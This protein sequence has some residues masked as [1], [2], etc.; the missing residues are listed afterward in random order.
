MRLVL[1]PV[2]SLQPAMSWRARITALIVACALFMQNLDSTVVATALP[3][4]ARAFHADPVHMSMALTSYMLSLSV[5]IPASEWVADRFGSRSVFRAAI[6]VF[7][8]S[9]VLCGRAGSLWFLVLARILQGMGGAM[10]VPVGRLVLLRTVAKSEL[11]AAMAWLSI[12]ALLGPVLGPPVGGFI[13]TY[14]SWHWIF[15]I[16]VPIG[17]L[18]A[19]LVTLYIGETAGKEAKPFDWAGL[20]FTAVSLVALLIGLESASRDVLPW[21]ESAGLLAIGAAAGLAY[22]FHARAT[23]HPLVDLG[24]LRIPTFGLSVAAASLFRIGIG[25]VPFLLPLLLQVGFGKSA[26]ESGLITFAS[27]AGA[28][29]MKPAAQYALRKFG[30]RAT[31]VCNGAISVITIALMAGFRPAW[32]V[33]AIYGVLLTGGFF[34]SLQFTAFNSIAFADIPPAK[35]SAATSFYSTAQHLSLTAGVAA[36]AA[37]LEI[38]SKLFG[39]APPSLG[40]YSFAFLA[41]AAVAMFSVPVSMRLAADAGVE[42]SGQPVR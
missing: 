34:R 42:L 4:M 2:A 36:G 13:V 11:V 19:V 29:V 33:A 26:A 37:A 32:P 17:V 5:F 23:E 3:A 15:D 25:A 9:S 8:L 14:V 6:I 38:S 31:L 27:S 1:P 28:L 40:D 18:G 7:T 35:M 10:M 24:L 22:W 41:V 39:H 20:G 12:P 21:P 16:N 30:F